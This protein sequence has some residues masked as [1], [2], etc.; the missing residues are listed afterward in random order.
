MDVPS[1]DG[2]KTLAAIHYQNPLPVTVSSNIKNLKA[3]IIRENQ[4]REFPVL[5]TSDNN[6]LWFWLV[7]G[8]VDLFKQSKNKRENNLQTT[9]Q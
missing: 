4:S 6:K 5:R 8:L 2:L 9:E 7:I 3:F 1:T